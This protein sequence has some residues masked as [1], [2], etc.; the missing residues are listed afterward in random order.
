[1]NV[2]TYY[3][4]TDSLKDPEVYALAYTKASPGRRMK[5]D[6]FVFD[7]DRRLSLGVEMLLI[8][9]LE[10]LGE[11]PDTSRIELVGNGKPKLA[12]SDIC[13]N[14]SHSEERVMCSVSDV[15]V[16]CDVEKINP[17]DLELA[18]RYF[19]GSEYDAIAAERDSERNELFYRFWT[20]KESFMKVTGLGFELDL[21]DFCIELGD[22]IGIR[23]HVDERAYHFKEY[24]VGD[25]YRYA[26]CSVNPVF[27]EKMIPAV[28]SEI[29]R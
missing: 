10:E 17:I 1:M 19:F 20:L 9:A 11:D 5:T 3:A 8:H 16:G 26:V 21:D 4:D 2:I 25:G 7:K 28:L 29:V 23:Q 27:E 15:D 24:S 18:H 14:L 13:F 22:K 6:S 12:D